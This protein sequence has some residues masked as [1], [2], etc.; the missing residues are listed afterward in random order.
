MRK[1]GTPTHT[2]ELPTTLVDI[3]NVEITYAQNKQVV[4]RKSTSDC[5]VTDNQISVT[6][7]QEDTFRFTDGVTV[8]IQLRLLDNVD[9]V[10]ISNI[11][12]VSCDRCLSDEV[13]E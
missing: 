9:H 10:F 6:L 4:L 7:T 12:R 1:G 13:L 8:E 11:M 5:T 3:K 2:F